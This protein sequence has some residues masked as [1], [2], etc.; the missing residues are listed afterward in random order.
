MTAAAKSGAAGA[1]ETQTAELQTAFAKNVTE[2]TTALT[3]A[4]EQTLT[5]QSS[6][7]T[8]AFKAALTEQSEELKKISA[9]HLAEQ[10][11]KWEEASSKKLTEQ[12]D[13]LKAEFLALLQQAVGVLSNQMAGVCQLLQRQFQN[14]TEHTESM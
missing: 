8:I 4:S 7:L 12:S 9:E 5:E 3:G 6:A 13:L 14:G 10:T 2:Q 11:S 1:N